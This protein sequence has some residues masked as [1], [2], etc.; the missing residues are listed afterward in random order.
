MENAINTRI[1]QPDKKVE[2]VQCQ[3]IGTIAYNN[4][5]SQ[6]RLSHRANNCASMKKSVLLSARASSMRGTCLPLAANLTLERDF[7]DDQ[8]VNNESIPDQSDDNLAGTSTN[9]SSIET[10]DEVFLLGFSNKPTK[11]P[12]TIS[13][14]NKATEDNI[15]TANAGYTANEYQEYGGGHNS[16][17]TSSALLSALSSNN[18]KRPQDSLPKQRNSSHGGLIHRAVPEH[19]AVP[20]SNM[21]YKTAVTSSGRAKNSSHLRAPVLAATKKN[22]ALSSVASKPRQQVTPGSA[23]QQEG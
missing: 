15:F 20:K 21:S 17:G 18:S 2:D 19:A 6:H 14:K 11:A 13:K 7:L 4:T 3:P 23:R 9:K 5:A 1:N 8:S 16:N 10:S 12:S 22:G